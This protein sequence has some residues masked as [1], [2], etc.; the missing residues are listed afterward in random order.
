MPQPWSRTVDLL[1]RERIHDIVVVAIQDPKAPEEPADP[2]GEVYLRLDHGY[3][4]FSSVNGHGG[5]LA[6]HLGALD[7]Q[8]YRDEFPGNVVIPVRVGNHFMGEAWE[9]RCVRIE[10]LTN[11]ESDLDQGIVR[12]VELVLEYGHRIVL[13]PMYTWGVRVGNTD[14]WPDAITEGPWTFQRHSVDCPP[15]PGAA[16]GVPKD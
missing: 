9:T 1:G 3:L 6:E 7:L 13:D 5:L 15:P 14:P 16:H 8:S 4:R 10:Y 2:M 11:E 12:S